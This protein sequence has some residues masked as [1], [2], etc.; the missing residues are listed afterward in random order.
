MNPDK[1][2]C[3]VCFLGALCLSGISVYAN[4]QIPDERVVQNI[5]HSIHCAKEAVDTENFTDKL[6]AELEQNDHVL[7][8]NEGGYLYSTTKDIEELKQE[9][10]ASNKG[11]E[12]NEVTVAEAK[13]DLQE[14]LHN[15]TMQH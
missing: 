3:F 2:I 8:L 15:A 4:E 11:V 13:E 10:K 9:F 6:F 7:Q 1:K 14:D 12:F 5:N